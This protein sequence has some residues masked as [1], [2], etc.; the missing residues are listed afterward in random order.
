VG[1][2][3]GSL[4]TIARRLGLTRAGLY[5]YC[6]DRQD[7][8]FRCYQRACELTQVDLQRAY[9]TPANGLDRLG[10]FL[11]QSTDVDHRPVAVLSELAFLSTEQQASIRKSRALNVSLLK[12]LLAEGQKDGSIRACDLDVVCQATFG[13][14]SWVTFS[15]LWTKRP[16]RAFAARMAA[17]IP[18]LVIGG[19][20]AD[21]VKLPESHKRITDVIEKIDRTEKEERLEDLARAGSMLF[22]SRGIDGV[23]LDDIALELNATKGVLYHYFT[24]KPSFVAFCYERAF[25]IY[26]RIMDLAESGSTGLECTMFA[27]ELNAEAQ[28][29][30]IHPLWLTTGIS[31]FRPNVQE[32][33]AVRTNSLAA[34][35]FAF[36]RRG[37]ADGSLRRFDLEPVKLAAPGSFTYLSGWLPQGNSRWATEVAREISR[38]QLLGLRQRRN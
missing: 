7:L 31:M 37:V 15:K 14:L 30:D 11:K 38:F 21:G 2:A 33:L 35:S 9:D 28:L 36:A 10:V 8:V 17:A 27:I 18:D 12:T 23:S 29:T 6:A 25:K 24:S 32:K 26:E 22:N 20:I 3:A 1:V 13:V 5:N 4:T 34:R 16:D 19:M